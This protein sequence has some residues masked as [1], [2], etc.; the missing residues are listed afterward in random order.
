MK[1]LFERIDVMDTNFHYSVDWMKRKYDEFNRK[2][3]NNQLPKNINF[4][5]NTMQ[6]EAA[7]ASCQHTNAPT[8]VP[9]E[10]KNGNAYIQ[11]LTITASDYLNN[12]TERE[13][14]QSLIHEMIHIWQFTQKPLSDWANN[15]GHGPSFQQKMNEI[16]RKANG[17]HIISQVNDIGTQA[18]HDNDSSNKKSFY[19]QLQDQRFLIMCDSD[20]PNDIRFKRFKNQ[21]ELNTFQNKYVGQHN[22]TVLGEAKPHDL[23]MFNQAYQ[24]V[25]V[26][27]SNQNNENWYSINEKELN[28]AI[29][30]G[31]ITFNEQE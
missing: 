23:D 28:N 14:E 7:Q 11:N 16:N 22:I 4:N 6:T 1:N 2:Y 9:G 3:F 24:N 20:N 21:N 13:A 15:D 10:M 12:I 26:S 8:G 27:T 29:N 18:R 30:A 5:I 17:E 31:I 19:Q 25:K